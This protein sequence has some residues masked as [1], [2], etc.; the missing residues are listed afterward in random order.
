MSVMGRRRIFFCSFRLLPSGDLMY[1]EMYTSWEKLTGK[2][3]IDGESKDG[4]YSGYENDTIV[5][6]CFPHSKATQG[7]DVSDV[8]ICIIKV[9]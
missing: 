7:A 8:V 9:Q 1:R 4:Q 2:F 6:Y 3:C 5:L